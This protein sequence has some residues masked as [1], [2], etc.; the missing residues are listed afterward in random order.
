MTSVL[1][2]WAIS[3]S[4]GVG[5]LSYLGDGKAAAGGG[6]LIPVK[7]AW[8]GDS[9]TQYGSGSVAAP[10]E[11]LESLL[12]NEGAY[13]VTNHGLSGD[14][15]SNML[16]RYQASIQAGGFQWLVFMGGVNDIKG[17]YL[18]TEGPDDAAINTSVIVGDAVGRG[19]RVV[20]LRVMPFMSY[21]EWTLASQTALE[22][23]NSQLGNICSTYPTQVTCID[24]Y[25]LMGNGPTEPR[26]LLPAYS[27]DGLHLS[28]PGVI[29]LSTLVKNAIA[30]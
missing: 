25:T 4:S 13:D 8:L 3:V 24:T 2:A 7:V 20:L 23:L 29:Q 18:A 12:L 14:I 1:L 26:Q 6:S 17:G 28:G 27:G 11:I 21:F 9:I 30:P 22:S 5:M 16:T 15:T 10:P 19:M